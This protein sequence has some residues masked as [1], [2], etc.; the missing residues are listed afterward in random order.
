MHERNSNNLS[1]A[2]RRRAVSN[3]HIVILQCKYCGADRR[4]VLLYKIRMK[5]QS[6][7]VEFR[8]RKKD[9]VMISYK[10]KC[11]FVLFKLR[12]YGCGAKP[13]FRC[14]ARRCSSAESSLS[15]LRALSRGY[16]GGHDGPNACAIALGSLERLGVCQG[17]LSQILLYG[18]H[19]LPAAVP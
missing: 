2:A 15:S 18:N 7:Q 3:M 13:P 17:V 11:S 4:G 5:L 8:L 19:A 9:C 1:C 12:S 6:F 14:A 16:T 10:T